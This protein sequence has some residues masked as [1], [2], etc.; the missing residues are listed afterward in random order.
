MQL[1]ALSP[2][3][4]STSTELVV[5]GVLLAVAALFVLAAFSDVPYPILFVL[6]GLTLGFVPGAPNVMLQPDLV[7]VIVLPPLL[8]SAAFFSSLRDLR[9][10]LRPISML[11]IGL[12]VATTFAVAAIAHA[13]IHGLSWEAAIVLG[14]VVSPTD[15]VAATAIAERLS[16]PR[17]VVTI[18]EGE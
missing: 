1:P 8:Y 12:V 13:A 4:L 3:A 9:A 14:A 6:G 15:P 18:V 7:L 17:R 11:S 5:L 2:A 10:N 16:V